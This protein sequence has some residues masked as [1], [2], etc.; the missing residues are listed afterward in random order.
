VNLHYDRTPISTID[1]AIPMYGAGEFQSPTRST[2]PL[3]SW[4][5]HQ[6]PMIRTLLQDIGMP[7]NNLHLEY[8]VKPPMG[9]G[10]ASHTDLMVISD[11]SSLA[12][13][14]KW[15][16]P[17]YETAGEWLNKGSN[18]LNRREVLSGWLGLLQ[19]HAQHTLNPTEFSDAVYQMVHRA[20]SACAAGNDPRMA[21]LVFEPSGDPRTASIQQIQDDLQ[22]LWKRLDYP[23][24][25]PF[26][27]IVVHM[28]PK[29]AF[30]TIISLPKG[31]QSTDMA[32]RAALSN[33]QLFDFTKYAL[34][35]INGGC[36]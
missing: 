27:L 31:S 28:N 24:T 17:R 9:K 3:L 21:Y 25:L 29:A 6:Q 1:A 30:N 16:E 8:K 35:T 26:Y 11:K 4:L 32:V 12:I 23:S 13:E 33:E 2:V 10:M 22:R 18:S 14:A 34:F 20:A 19:K 7:T 15:T 5:K 36:T